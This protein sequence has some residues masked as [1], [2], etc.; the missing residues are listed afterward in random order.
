ML[1]RAIKTMAATI[2]AVGSGV[3]VLIYHRV[4]SGAASAV[5]LDPAVFTEQL[6]WL[7]EHRRV[8]TLDTAIDALVAG[9]PC[10]DLVVVTF[11]DGTSDFAEHVVLALVATNTPAT[12]H[13]ATDFVD[14]NEPF[15]WGAPPLSW[16]SLRDA[17]ST[18]L[19][20]I[21]SHTHTHRL[22]DRCDEAT[23]IEELDRSID[24]IGAELGEAA[25]HF[26]Y[27]KAVAGSAAADAAVRARFR[28]AALA[29]TR[30]NRAGHTRRASLGRQ[31]D[32]T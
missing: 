17:A 23:I 8:A 24:R 27:P 3:V 29:G 6:R 26:A 32:P 30:A 11:D 22:L 13:V 4:G 25:A 1:A 14:H 28:S 21:G 19:V 15:P 10:D 2:P 20:T 16:A 18:G 7:H 9:R 31:P 5:D 12:L